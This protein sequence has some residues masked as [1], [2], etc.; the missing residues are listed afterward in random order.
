ML[1]AIY[2]NLIYLSIYLSIHLSIY[3]CIYICDTHP[4]VRAKLAAAAAGKSLESLHTEA[5]TVDAF[6][7][8]QELETF[9]KKKEGKV[10]LCTCVCVYVR[11]G[12]EPGPRI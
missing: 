7:S 8:Q 10:C 2:R 1:S 9:K 4:Q 11:R 3:T 6:A 5:K 12:A